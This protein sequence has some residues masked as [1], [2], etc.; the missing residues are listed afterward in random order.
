MNKLLGSSADENKLS[1]TIKS[2]LLAIVPI[3]IIVASQFGLDIKSKEITDIIVAGFG[4]VSAVGIFVG[5]VR[6]VI[7]RIK[8]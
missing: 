1:L 3:A 4:A 7:Y 6:K 5:L 8:S 2:A